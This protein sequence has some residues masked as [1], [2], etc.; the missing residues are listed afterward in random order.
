MIKQHITSGL[1]LG[2]NTGISLDEHCVN[3]DTSMESNTSSSLV[4]LHHFLVATAT[5]PCTI[6]HPY[7]LAAQSAKAS[8]KLCNQ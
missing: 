4:R 1:R 2:K 3:D 6:R 5:L 8:R 7:G